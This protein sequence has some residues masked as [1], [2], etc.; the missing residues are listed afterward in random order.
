MTTAADIMH[1]GAHWIPATD[2]LVRAAETMRDLNV[3][4]L[5]VADENRRMCGIVTD[6]DIVVKCVAE[7]RNPWDVTVGEL[8]QGTPRWIDSTADVGEVLREMQEHQIRRLPVIEDKQLVGMI[9][10][11]DLA[12]HLDDDQLADWAHKIYS[13]G[14]PPRRNA[15]EPDLP[16]MG[17]YQP[18]ED[19]QP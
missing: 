12:Q 15:G 16:S 3:G 17:G 13:E 2:N 4:A 18:D 7:G 8:T 19:D 6:R 5:P 9:T 11:A 1:S 14:K 10:E